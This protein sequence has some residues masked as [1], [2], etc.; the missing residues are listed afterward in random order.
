MDKTIESIVDFVQTS[1]DRSPSDEVIS[2]VEQHLLDSLGCMV[3]AHDA[4]PARVAAKLA[5]EASQIE[6]ATVLTTGTR[7]TTEAAA[8][9]NTILVRYLDFNDSYN[10]VRGGL[11]PSDIIPGLLAVAERQELSGA[12]LITAIATGYE[13][14]RS[15]SDA[16]SL[17]EVGW[18]HVLWLAVAQGAVSARM[19]GCDAA[20]IGNAVSLSAVPNVPL[21]QTRAGELSMWKAVAAAAAARAGIFA[22]RLAN[23]GITG[24]PE[25]FEGRHGVFTSVTGPFEL[26]LPAR[27]IAAVNETSIKLLPAEYH[28]LAILDAVRGMR[29][30]LALDQITA[31]RIL[32]YAMVFHEIADDPSKWRPSNRE[33]ADHSLPFLLANMLASGTVAIDQFSE[34]SFADPRLQELM[35][36]VS[37]TENPEYTKL[38]PHELRSEITIELRDGT[39]VSRETGY[40][41]GHPKNPADDADV[42]AKFRRLVT[43]VGSSHWADEIEQAVEELDRAPTV[44]ELVGCVA[45]SIEAARDTAG[46]RP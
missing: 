15:L 36:M 29:E 12:E 18:D 19:L 38:F 45:R 39:S 3:A 9:A 17:R 16:V 37:V 22:A 8:F 33:T 27:P 25:A 40:P 11:H 21:R 13:L 4:P 28:S 35:D 2:G 43:S 1:F 32:S 5:E 6:G 31:V 42:L 30:S 46:M 41:K 23:G 20:Q 14:L 26:A 24:P 34:A 44:T 10:N 7:A